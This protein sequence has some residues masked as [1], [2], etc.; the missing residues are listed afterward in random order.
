MNGQDLRIG[1][2][3]LPRKGYEVSCVLAKI[4]NPSQNLQ[5]VR[6]DVS[7]IN[8]SFIRRDL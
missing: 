7:W 8:H 1:I 6:I 2:V 4:T 3:Q 5:N